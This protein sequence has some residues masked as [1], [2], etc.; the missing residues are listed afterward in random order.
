MTD[1]TITTTPADVARAFIEAWGRQDLAAMRQW[2]ADD[3]TFEGP[4]AQI[5]GADAFLTAAAQFGQAVTGAEVL[6]VLGDDRQAIVMYDMRTGPFGT[7]RAADH[8]VVQDGKITADKLVFDT[9]AVRTAEAPPGATT[10][11]G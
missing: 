11:P 8:L 3:M 10:S 7:L 6:A 9:Y 4:T 5:T 2:L 1:D